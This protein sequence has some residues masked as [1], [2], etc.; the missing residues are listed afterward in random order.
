V[1]VAVERNGPVRA[2]LVDSD[3]VTDLMPKIT[4]FV[5]RHSHLMTD[6]LQ[7]YQKIGRSYSAHDWINHGKK[8]FARGNA[9]NNTA[10]SFNA[11]L[12]RTKQGVFHYLSKKHLKRYLQEIGFRWN[13]RI[14]KM[15]RTRKGNLKI[16]MTP[17][18]LIDRLHSLLSQAPGRQLRRTI[19]G[20]IQTVDLNPI[21]V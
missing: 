5:D 20:G 8:E 18:P 17:M 3:K 16:V 2:A 7:A 10:E 12:E 14:P 13:H 15:K 1:L 21:S 19:N 11:I 6:Q 9:H 4:Q